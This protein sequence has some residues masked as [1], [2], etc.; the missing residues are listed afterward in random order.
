[1][2]DMKIPQV[3]IAVNARCG[4]AC[5]F[6]RPSGEGIATPAR[7]MLDTSDVI[8]L[9][10]A[11]KM[12]G[13]REFKLTGG[14]PALWPPLVDCVQQ[15]KQ[16]VGVDRLEV[17]SR[18]PQIGPLANALREAGLDQINMSLDTLHPDV[19]RRITGINDLPQ[20]L[21]ALQ[22]VSR[23]GIPC[24]VNTVVM[25]GVN[26]TE[27]PAMVRYCENEGVSQLKLLDVIR[28][29]DTG[30]ESHQ[31][32]LIQI[33]A[34][35]MRDL[36]TPLDGITAWLEHQ[37]TSVRRVLQGGLGHPMRAYRMHSG[38]DV[39]VK[40]H[41]AGAWYSTVC[42]ACIHYPCHDALMAV[43]VTSDAR[44]QFCLL[45][46]DTAINLASALHRDTSQLQKT[47]QAA[48]DVYARATFKAEETVCESR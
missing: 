19:H 6:C 36:Y 23:S 40:D 29:L 9:C 32:R 11:F 26:D 25:L 15:L 44:I 8:E 48:L 17:I 20:V 2:L 45:R 22:Q 24:K 1:M 7:S 30:T 34:R 5:F 37:A 33:G 16:E 42:D 18:H 43:R 10:M 41:R 28:D 31:S 4:R 47:I 27:I 35:S 12:C 39:V 14:D 21:Q 13:A 38:M 46:E 3:R